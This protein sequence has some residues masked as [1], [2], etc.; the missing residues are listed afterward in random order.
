MQRVDRIGPDLFFAS[1]PL[2]PPIYSS[3]CCN[4]L[5]IER[6]NIILCH[7]IRFLWMLSQITTN[8]VAENNRN[9]FLLQL[10]RPEIWT[11]SSRAKSRCRNG[12]VPSGVSTGE[13]VSLSFPALELHSLNSLTHSSF[14]RLQ[15]HSRSIFSLWFWFHYTAFFFSV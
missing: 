3:L 4:N 11:K 14:L 5:Q 1:H 2:G 7:H 6:E 8:L 13:S 15:S 10:Q 9:F 12:S